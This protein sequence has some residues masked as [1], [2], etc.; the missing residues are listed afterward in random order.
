MQSDNA[1]SYDIA[2]HYHIN[3]LIFVEACIYQTICQGWCICSMLISKAVNRILQCVYMIFY[4][5]QKWINQLQQNIENIAID[6]VSDF[7]FLGITINEHLSWKSHI[8]KLS[9]KI[10]KTMGVLNKLKHF[11]PLN[12]RVMIYNSLILSHLNYWILAWGYRCEWITKLQ[13]HIVRILSIN[14]YNA[15]TE[16]I[17]QI[18]RLLNVNDI[19][20]LPELKF[21]YKYEN[22]LMS[23]YFQDMLFKPYIHS[24]ETTSQ[25][26]IH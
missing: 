25:G 24:H 16:P 26:K 15:Q 18:L 7:K 5:P 6:R 10:S 13:K 23:Y 4:I 20:K 11:V 9:N 19:L 14:K 21:H 1:F 22:N 12:A 2:S 17:L 8:D 3:D